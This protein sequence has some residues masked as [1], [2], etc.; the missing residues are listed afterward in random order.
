[1]SPLVIGAL[2]VGLVVGFLVRGA[3]AGLTEV[4]LRGAYVLLRVG[5]VGLMLAGVAAVIWVVAR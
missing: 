2:L 5:Q 1:M 4:A 3:A